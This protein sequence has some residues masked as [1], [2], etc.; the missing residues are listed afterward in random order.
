M[1]SKARSARFLPEWLNTPHIAEQAIAVELKGNQR[2]VLK[3]KAREVSR[4][5]SCAPFVL[6]LI[7][8]QTKD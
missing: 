2:G 6:R 8:V 5:D 1:A 4:E 7:R 3:V